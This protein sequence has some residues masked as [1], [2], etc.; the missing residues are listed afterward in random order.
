MTTF[1]LFNP[2]SPHGLFDGLREESDPGVL[3][4]LD[5]GDF[6]AKVKCI[7]SKLSFSL[8][9]YTINKKVVQLIGR[10]FMPVWQRSEM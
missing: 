7:I 8:T 10:T 2:G 4:F 6:A 5:M 9:T 1:Y 3:L